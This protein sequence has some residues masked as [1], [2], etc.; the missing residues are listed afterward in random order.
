MF[1]IQ[2]WKQALGF[3]ALGS[4]FTIVGLVLSPVTAQQRGNFGEI[5]CT[6]LKVVDSNGKLRVALWSVFSGGR[7]D[8]FGNDEKSKA[9]L[10]VTKHGGHVIANGEDGRSSADLH[11]CEHGGRVDVFGND[12]RSKAALRASERGGRLDIF[13][14]DGV[15]KEDLREAELIFGQ[16]FT[17]AKSHVKLNVTSTGGKIWVGRE[18]KGAAAIGVN[19]FGNGAVSTWDRNGDKRR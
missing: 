17:D 15:S 16:P 7:V 11:V 2:N 12:G 1:R 10:R 8:V 18:G 6:G 4:V 19:V 9:T 14:N 13:G 5:E 3:M